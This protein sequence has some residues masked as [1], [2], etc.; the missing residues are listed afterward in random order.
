MRTISEACGGKLR[1][2]GRGSPHAMDPLE[3]ELKLAKASFEAVDPRSVGIEPA[4]LQDYEEAM[5]QMVKKGELPG[6]ASI[7]MRKGK[8]IHTGAWGLADVEQG[9]PFGLD[10]FCRMF[11]ATKSF[12]ATAFFR[13]VEAGKISPEDRLDKYISA[14]G[15]VTV[16]VE[17]ADSAVPAKSPILLKHLM[18]HTSG[19]AYPP[20]LGEKAED[21]VAK[22]YLKL[23]QMAAKGTIAS[24]KDLVDGIAKVP[25]SGHPGSGYYYGFSFDVLARVLEVSTGKSLEK[26][27]QELVF[28]PLGMK[29]TKWAV[30][31]HEVGR[32]AA[33]YANRTSWKLLYGSSKATL[34]RP[35][36]KLYRI[37]GNRALDSHYVDGQ[38]CRVRSGGGFMGYLHGGLVSTVSDT[39]RFVYMLTKRGVTL[40][41]ERFL[42]ANT[43]AVME[44]NR[45]KEG[46][47]VN[48][49]GNIGVF[50]TDKAN[51]HYG[52]GGAACTYW[53]IDREDD[54]S[55]VW[56]TQHINM[57][58]FEELKGIDAKKADLWA[59]MHEAA[60]KGV[61]AASR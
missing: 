50:R 12:I 61:K 24:L 48:F 51:N 52:M 37:D 26:A 17:G 56:F 46:D 10:T 41:G 60:R 49:L 40:N 11:C 31:R 3:S 9:T 1:I 44:R 27:L 14:F 25:L 45:V 36:P 43:V 15:N 22:A 35:R 6:I 42:K 53:S 58:E 38:Q 23:Q 47:P 28:K 7:V 19:I 20:D 16:Q 21:D 57:P 32:L 54:V 39:F 18:S 59:L 4:A 5:Q 30:A 13:L 8:V 34:V 29:D 2:R 33:C 55:I